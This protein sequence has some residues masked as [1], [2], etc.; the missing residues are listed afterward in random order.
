MRVYVYYFYTYSPKRR[1]FF[2]DSN[3]CSLT[4]SWGILSND[5]LKL[6]ENLNVFT[7]TQKEF[8]EKWSK[9]RTYSRRYRLTNCFGERSAAIIADGR[10]EDKI[11][12]T[13]TDGRLLDESLCCD[14][15]PSQS[16]SSGFALMVTCNWFD[17][18]LIEFFR[19]T[20]SD[21]D[22]FDGDVFNGDIQGVTLTVTGISSASR[23]LPSS[24]VSDTRARRCGISLRV[25]KA[26]SYF[27]A[28]EWIYLSKVPSRSV[29]HLKLD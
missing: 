28:N 26:K 12:C 14:V 5:D 27:L 2:I 24:F 1:F 29:R 3:A 4:G 17:D 20:F 16:M 25:L 7:E 19:G 18:R 11:S 13:K 22:E 9:V 21:G 23:S 8:S 15:L 10:L 6:I